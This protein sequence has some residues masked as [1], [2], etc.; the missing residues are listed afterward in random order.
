MRKARNRKGEMNMHKINERHTTRAAYVY[1][2][3]S[4]QAQVQHNQESSRRQYALAQKAQL[5]G[6]RQ[7]EIVD[8]DMGCSGSGSVHRTGFERMVAAVGMGQVGAVF[9]I[10][11]SRL[12]RNN[13]DWYNLVDICGMFGTLIIDE[14]GIYDATVLNDRL[15]LGLKGT[16]SEFELALIGQRMRAGLLQ[17]ARRGEL[18][19]TMAIGY[20]R[21]SD[22]RCEK[23]PDERVR[24]AID[25]VFR[26]F[27]QTGSARQTL[28]WFRQEAVEIPATIYGPQGRSITWKVPTYSTII[29]FLS[30][31]IYAGT[32]A[33]GRDRTETYVEAGHVRKRV[34][35]DLRQ[36]QWQVLLK[37]HHKGYI[38]WQQYE[39]NRR[40]L[41]ENSAMSGFIRGHGAPR[42]GPCLLAGLLRCSRCGRKLR[43]GYSGADGTIRR[44]NC[45][46]GMCTSGTRRCIS[47]A[48]S[49]VDEAM[50]REILEIVK[51]A[52]VEASIKALEMSTISIQEKRKALELSLQQARYEAQR[53]FTQYNA[54]DPVNRLV[55]FELE[56]RWN[57]T[58][59]KV[60]EIEQEF[61]ASDNELRRQSNQDHRCL[62]SLADD[63]SV[64]WYSEQSDVRIKKMIVRTLVEEIVADV[65]SQ[66]EYIVL[67]IHWK[68]GNHSVVRVKKTAV[69]HHRYRTDKEAI[70]IVRELAAIMPDRTI[71]ATLNRLSHKTAHGQNWTQSLVRSLRKSYSV[72][73]YD[74]TSQNRQGRV[75]MTEAAKVLGT[76][77]ML[78]R[79]LIK[80]GIIESKQIV[81]YAPHLI[82]VS[83]LKTQ[84]VRDAVKS[85]RRGPTVPLTKDENQM[86]LNLS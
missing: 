43:V 12:A 15:L 86:S 64:V 82:A 52:A 68:G 69:G 60:E 3:Q 73:A 63:L 9:S 61:T 17:K 76:Y 20:I 34:K 42:N 2:R 32:Y 18:F 72:P 16:M 36:D 6:W 56:R 55:A 22:G 54:V 53:A 4:T 77:P 75:T 26:K 27:E 37:D 31:P 85:I 21:T 5:L 39:D 44:Y 41:I 59:Q 79:R 47:F 74:S 1:I 10:E 19:L 46:G 48:G 33:F 83:Q 45:I 29:N 57:S 50:E 8:E 65:D 62:L 30:N 24:T 14:D 35:T 78:I 11:A 28:L 66:P 58:M 51:P 71:A 25:L 38:T 67:T 40:K 80:M 84:L 81:P 23:D 70:D 49:K 7:I 13:R